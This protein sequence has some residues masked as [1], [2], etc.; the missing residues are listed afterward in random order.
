MY[1]LIFVPVV[2]LF[3]F[4]GFTKPTFKEWK[5]RKKKYG[6]VEPAVKFY[7]ISACIC[8]HTIGG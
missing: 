7:V 3:P 4:Q 1:A 5:S 6:G 8:M 2:Q